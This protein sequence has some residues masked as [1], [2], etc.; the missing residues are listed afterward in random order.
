VIALFMNLALASCSHTVWERPGSSTA[1]FKKD[2]K[3]CEDKKG[4]AEA[5]NAGARGTNTP[6]ME[7]VKYRCLKSRGWVPVE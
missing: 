2:L 7:H 3:E 6:N 5:A 4:A 1:D